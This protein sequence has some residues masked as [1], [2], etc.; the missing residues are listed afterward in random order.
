MQ[1]TSVTPQSGQ[2]TPIGPQT[3]IELQDQRVQQRTE[4]RAERHA[5]NQE[6]GIPVWG[7][8]LVLVGAI[9]LLGNFGFNFGW[10]FGLALGAWF[11]YLG[12]R[13]SQEGRQINWWLVGL[14][15]LIGLG[16]VSTGF[17]DLPG[18]PCSCW[19]GYPF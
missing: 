4:R 3:T 8:F 15:L 19:P 6:A 13:H 7:V 14:G 5:Q 17:A 10:I 2:T 1:P 11:V 9:A 18:S 12:V 16:A